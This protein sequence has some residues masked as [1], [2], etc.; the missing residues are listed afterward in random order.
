LRQKVLFI[1]DHLRPFVV[2]F[3]SLFHWRVLK[4]VDFFLQL[5]NAG[6]VRPSI[7]GVLKFGDGLLEL[8]NFGVIA[9]VVIDFDGCAYQRLNGLVVSSPVFEQ[10]RT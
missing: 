5:V 6:D 9:I 3:L 1:A 8:G 10:T 2:Y 4:V 7:I